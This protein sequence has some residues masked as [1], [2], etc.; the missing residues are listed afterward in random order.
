MTKAFKGFA[1]LLTLGLSLTILLSVGMGH[2]MGEAPTHHG[3]HECCDFAPMPT[4]TAP[5]TLLVLLPTFAAVLSVALLC[6]PMFIEK[7]LRFSSHS[8]PSHN[9]RLLKGIVQR[10]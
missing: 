5:S 3:E 1:L 10:E 8:I 7:Q 9:R 4:S 6:R 2:W